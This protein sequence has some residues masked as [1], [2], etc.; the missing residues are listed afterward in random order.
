LSVSPTRAYTWVASIGLFLQGASTLAANLIPA[1]DRAFP[2]LLHETQMIPSHS[3][4]HTASG[5][6]GFAALYAG[7]SG[8]RR[9]ALWFGLFYVALAIVGVTTGW[10]LGIGLQPFDHSFHALLGGFGLIAVAVEN[11]RGRATTRRH[12]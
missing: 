4:L 6:I 1:F 11:W 2:M 3:L 12:A 7:G 8:P 9:F 5:L 10:Q